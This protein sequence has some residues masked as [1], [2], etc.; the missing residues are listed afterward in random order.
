[1]E[2]A[3][4]AL[5]TDADRVLATLRG[6]RAIGARIV[7]DNFRTGYSSL[8][9]LRQFPFDK[10]KI[11]KSFVDGIEADGNGY[12]ILENV[13]K[14]AAQLGIRTTAEGIETAEQRNVVRSMGYDEIQGR[15]VGTPKS[16]S[17]IAAMLARRSG[18]P[19]LAA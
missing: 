1:M 15:L 17:E 14:L 8:N 5:L 2:I 12:A 19:G 9:Y 3:E 13:A 11:D 16:A 18:E 7:L 10:L 6:L 4:A